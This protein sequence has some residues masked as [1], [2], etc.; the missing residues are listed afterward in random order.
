MGIVIDNKLK[1]E[2][3]IGNICQKANNKLNALARLINYMDTSSS[4][5][6]FRK[7]GVFRNLTKFIGKHLYHSL[8]FNKVAGLEDRP[9]K[10]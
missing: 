7:K 9:L 2:L 1:F 6:I 10:N 3:H 4:P 8:F 5:E